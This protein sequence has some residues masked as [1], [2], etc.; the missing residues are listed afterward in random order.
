MLTYSSIRITGSQAHCI[1]LSCQ[2]LSKPVN[3]RRC[4]AELS[5]LAL[6]SRQDDANNE[7]DMRIAQSSRQSHSEWLS[8]AGSYSPPKLDNA[9]DRFPGTMLFQLH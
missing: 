1:C 7:N 3:R 9:E 2:E 8:I 4:T 6:A 5:S